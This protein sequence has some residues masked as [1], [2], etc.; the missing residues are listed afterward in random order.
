M[1]KCR[2]CGTRNREKYA[3]CVQCGGPLVSV[4]SGAKGSSGLPA[5]IKLAIAMVVLLGVTIGGFRWMARGSSSSAEAQPAHVD[6]NSA[7][8]DADPFS[9]DEALE[10]TESEGDAVLIER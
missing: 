2:L 9:I 7:S 5:A 6:S 3:S 4:A 1:K 8:Q 10:A